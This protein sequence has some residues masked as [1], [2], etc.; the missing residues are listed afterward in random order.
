MKLRGTLLAMLFVYNPTVLRKQFG[1]IDLAYTAKPK[2]ETGFGFS[3]SI[4]ALVSV[5]KL[6]LSAHQYRAYYYYYRL[7]VAH[8]DAVSFACCCSI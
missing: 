3:K 1:A 5:G 7:L 4:A 2:T 8:V 6:Q